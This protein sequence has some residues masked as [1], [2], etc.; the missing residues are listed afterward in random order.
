MLEVEFQHKQNRGNFNDG[1]RVKDSEFNTLTRKI[2]F[3]K[4]IPLSFD[5]VSNDVNT[6]DYTPYNI[7]V[8]M[9]KKMFSQPLHILM[10]LIMLIYLFS[11]VFLKDVSSMGLKVTFYIHFIIIVF[12]IICDLYTF[13]RIY[14]NDLKTNS[15]TAN[16]YD[17]E[18]RCFVTATWSDIRVGHIIKVN[19]DEIVPADIVILETMDSHHTCDVDV[20]AITGVFDSFMIK[21]SC[22]DTQTPSIKTIKFNEYVKNIKGMLKYEEPNSNINSFNARLK[23]ESFPRASDITEENFVMRGSTVKNIRCIYGLVVYTGME[24]KIMQI[25]K[26]DKSS[27]YIVKDVSN[28]IHTSWSIVQ[29]CIIAYYVLLTIISTLSQ[30]HNI[31]NYCFYEYCPIACLDVD[32]PFNQLYRFILQYLFTYHFVIPFNW[33]NLA[34]LSFYIFQCFVKWDIKIRQKSINMVDII[35]KHSLPDFGQVKYILADKTGTLTSRKFHLK[36]CSI[37]GKIYTF[38]P[39][40]KNDENFIFRH[41]KS[42]ISDLELFQELRSNSGFSQNI[43]NFFEHLCLC[44]NVRIRPNFSQKTDNGKKDKFANRDEIKE[45]INE[46][47]F[48]Q[49]EQSNQ[50]NHQK[51]IKNGSDNFSPR[52]QIPASDPQKTLKEEKVFS[53]SN[54]EDKATLNMMKNFGYNVTKIKSE[55]ITID[56]NGEEKIFSVVGMNKYSEERQR[57]SIIVKRYRNDP[58]SV[59]LCKGYDLSIFRQ[60]RMDSSINLKQVIDQINKFSSIGYRYFIF[61]K[62]DLTEDETTSYITKYR[63]AE[64]FVLHRDTHFEMLANEYE[65]EMEFVGVL[66]FEEKVSDDLRYSINKLIDSNINLW[67]V[68][69]DRRENV[70]AVCR[71]LDMLKH[72]GTIVEFSE[73]DDLDDLDIKM[74]MYLLQFLGTGGNMMKMKTRQGLNINVE[75]KSGQYRGKSKELTILIHGSCFNTIYYDTRLFQCFITLLSYTNHLFAY[76]FTPLNKYLLCRT[77]KKFITKNSKVLAIGD[78]LNDFMMLKEADLSIGI[79]S[80]EILQVRNTCDV[81]VSKFP[82]IIDLL[83]VHGTWNARRIYSICYFSLY[84]NIVIILPFSVYQNDFM[85]GSSFFLVDRTKLTFEIL[86]INLMIMSVFC[87]DT[88]VERPLIGLNSSIYLGNFKDKKTVLFS[89][90]K[91]LMKANIDSIIIYYVFQNMYNPVNAEGENIDGEVYRFTIMKTTYVLIFIKLY[92]LKISNINF[93]TVLIG[94]ISIASLNGISFYLE[95]TEIIFQQYSSYLTLILHSLLAIFICYIY[96]KLFELYSIKMNENLIYLLSTKFRKFI[97]EYALF[98]NFDEVVKEL[99]IFNMQ[100]KS[101]INKI[102]YQEVMKKINTYFKGID[103]V[104]D[105][106]TDINNDEIVKL[107]IG[108]HFLKFYDEKL[109]VDYTNQFYNN[110]K[111]SFLFY[112]ISMLIFWTADA[113]LQSIYFDFHHEKIS[114]TLKLIYIVLGFILLLK[115][116]RLKFLRYYFFYYY[117]GLIIEIICIYAEQANNDTKICIEMFIFFSF[118]LIFGIKKFR[119]MVIGAFFYFIIILPSIYLN[120]FGFKRITNNENFL[121]S[122]LPLL[123]HRSFFLLGVLAV[124]VIYGYFEELGSRISFLKYNK[125]TLDYKKD[126]EIYSNLV[127]EFVRDKMKNGVRGAAAIDYE[128]VTILFCDIGDFDKLVASMSPKDMINLLDKIYN[129]FDQLCSLHG[130]QKIETVG[131]TYMAAGGLRETETDV[132][133]SVLNRHHAIRSFE[134]AVDMLDVINKMTLENGE[135]LKIKIGLHT[136][137][138]IAAVVGNHKPQFSLIGDTINTT[139][140]MC[141]YSQEMAI[142]CS[143]S[144]YENI[145]NIYFDCTVSQKEVKGKGIMNLHLFKPFKKMKFGLFEPESRKKSLNFQKLGILP[146]T[147]QTSLRNVMRRPRSKVSNNNIF[148]ENSED[149]SDGMMMNFPKR[150]L[151]KPTRLSK[152]MTKFTFE[153]NNLVVDENIIFTDSYFFFKFKNAEARDLYDKY[154]AIKFN[155]SWQKVTIMNLFYCTMMIIGAYNISDNYIEEILAHSFSG[156]KISLLTCILLLTY[157]LPKIIPEHPKLLTK[158][159]IILYLLLSIT[160]QV[161]MNFLKSYFTINLLMEQTFTILVVTYQ[162]LLSYRQISA[163]LVL[164]ILLFIIN[165]AINSEKNLFIKYLVLE[166]IICIFIFVFV[167]IREYNS[168]FEY[169]QNRN[170][171]EKLKN[172]EKLLFNLMP[173]H[174]V[175][176]LKEDIPVADVI[177]NVTMLFADIVRFTDYSSQREPVEVVDMLTELFKEFDDACERYNVYKVHTIGDCYVVMSFT[178]KVPMNERNYKEEAKNVITMGESMIETIKTVRKAV[179]FEELNMRI[180]IHT[181]KN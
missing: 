97:K 127:P 111:Q 35:N 154:A 85:D 76:S 33:F 87:F 68:S 131:K 44:H 102:S 96:E 145:K 155:N 26:N 64:N 95:E 37:Y 159:T 48:N 147:K 136:G 140:R 51:E 148:I 129:T 179:N 150:D 12:Q 60:L 165:M 78:G 4:G 38:D 54:A 50:I 83:L 88:F 158:I 42:D 27:K 149:M 90:L 162:G 99:A 178:G 61:C 74:N 43:K 11:Y 24:T 18:H 160:I 125:K 137:K 114:K 126:W 79:R 5:Y 98:L 103:P 104:L 47:E 156:T 143:E 138:V 19:K 101:S 22:T 93:I 16:I 152:I 133:P 130:L 56:I 161:E 134:L 15:Q 118:P 1:E 121:F 92:V 3:D 7:F 80:R 117:L 71:N 84:A 36:A 176:N 109:E 59:L 120:D 55:K 105:N 52:S 62:R 119:T 57:M 70:V 14:Q 81:I 32:K 172:I 58:E 46:N 39:L 173:Q 180:G 151:K 31:Y 100:V 65:V 141:A 21:K 171:N 167:L 142:N 9:M 49:V 115:P 89:F 10:L 20:S 135:T 94:F 91:N 168:T 164:H 75:A 128:V 73:N 86:I 29:Y 8:F 6:I 112:L 30:V 67:V 69:G 72:T 77:V 28:I 82:Q 166:I 144:T 116:I 124:M 2:Q 108:K 122:N 45:I 13:F 110:V 139:A 177:Y 157:R 132:D 123:Y 53:S 170:E 113:I 107:R 174:V 175:Q 41:K 163:N 106:M 40:E 23:L 66:F 153:G 17:M 169:L 25:L 146:I 63:S 181:V 34:T